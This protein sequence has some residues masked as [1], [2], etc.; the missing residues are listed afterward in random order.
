MLEK[1]EVEV[2]K[3]LWGKILIQNLNMKLKMFV[4]FSVAN[5]NWV[6]TIVTD[7]HSIRRCEKSIWIFAAKHVV[8]GSLEVKSLRACQS[9]FHFIERTRAFV[10]SIKS[11]F[12]WTTPF[13]SI[14]L[15]IITTEISNALT[16]IVTNTTSSIKTWRIALRWEIIL[17]IKYLLNFY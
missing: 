10:S 3:E 15:T 5:L 17:L 1:F 11:Q 16:N 8:G 12:L 4:L 2:E 13:N 7:W 6:A 9:T 14:I